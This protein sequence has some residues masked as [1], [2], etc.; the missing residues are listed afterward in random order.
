M[1][2]SGVVFLVVHSMESTP[3]SP[4]PARYQFIMMLNARRLE[5]LLPWQWVPWIRDGYCSIM[6]HSLYLDI[7]LLKWM[8]ML[9][10]KPRWSNK[11]LDVVLEMHLTS[12]DVYHDTND[13]LS[14]PSTVLPRSLRRGPLWSM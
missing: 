14:T 9:S 2:P 3:W 10:C 4:Q 5:G 7:M 13:G 1:E 8:T 11:Y 6:S 12:R